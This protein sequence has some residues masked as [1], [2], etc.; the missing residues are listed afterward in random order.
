MLAVLLAQGQAVG[1]QSAGAPALATSP[2]SGPFPLIHSSID[3]PAKAYP[4]SPRGVPL[5]KHCPHKSRRL[6]ARDLRFMRRPAPRNGRETD[7]MA[8]RAVR[9]RGRGQGRGRERGGRAAGPSAAAPRAPHAPSRRPASREVRSMPIPN[10]AGGTQG[11]SGWACG[12][13]VLGLWGGGRGSP[14]SP[15][16]ILRAPR[17]AG[18]SP[19]LRLFLWGRVPLPP[20]R[21]LGLPSSRCR[22]WSPPG[23]PTPALPCHDLA[24]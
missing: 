21:G 13:A 19:R 6:P 9:I 8:H 22:P 3:N 1:L 4:P 17:A 24:L 5:F 12:Q 18:P 11:G 15:S 16:G 20:A 14:P 23:W 2:I 7:P 10:C